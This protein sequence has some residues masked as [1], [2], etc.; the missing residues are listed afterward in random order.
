MENES[1]IKELEYK[2]V[3]YST[4]YYRGHSSFK[5]SD[6]LTYY[7]IEDVEF[8]S[9]ERELRSL[10]PGNVVFKKVGY[11]EANSEDKIK[12]KRPMLSIVKV[13][14]APE[15]E[16]LIKKG[17]TVVGLKL[18]GSACSLNFDYEQYLCTFKNAATRGSGEEGEDI[19]A[20]TNYVQGFPKTHTSSEA[21]DEVRG[22]IVIYKNDFEDLKKEMEAR[23]LEVPESQRNIV[24]GLLHRKEH[25]DLS[26]YLTFVAYDM[27]SNINYEYYSEKLETLRGH[28]FTT[29]P[30]DKIANNLRDINN[31]VEDYATS[32]DELDMLTDGL[33]FRID[34]IPTAEALGRTSHHWKHSVAYK[35]ETDSA[36]TE[37]TGFVTEVNRTGKISYVARIKP[38]KV[39]GATVKRCTLHNAS[40]IV[41]HNL[42]IGAK[43]RITRA[44]EVI[45]KFLSVIESAE[46]HNLSMEC[47]TCGSPLVWSKSKIDLFCSDVNC[48]GRKLKQLTHFA[49]VIKFD[50]MSEKTITKLYEDGYVED[51]KDFYN[52]T[53]HA[54]L[55]LE[56]EG[57]KS[58][59]NKYK[60]IQEKIE[61]TPEKF[62]SAISVEGLGK[63]VSKIIIE[64]F[65]T[66]P[67][68]IEYADNKDLLYER[69]K[70]ISGIGKIIAGNISDQIGY[71]KDIYESLLA[72]RVRIKN[73]EKKSFT[74]SIYTGVKFII[75]GATETGKDKLYEMIEELGGERVSTVLRSDILICNETST[76]KYKKA[77]EKNKVI[78]TESEFMK[79]ID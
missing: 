64:K 60:A 62:L 73:K 37:I 53:H 38:T 40:H 32:K 24:S 39:P 65:V 23:G 75:S 16:K 41:I 49:L 77:I 70:E 11:I 56:R 61:I 42:N 19:T 52:I 36:D 12:H 54:F 47:P 57:K 25:Q 15:V 72:Q 48:K 44:N 45:P 66:L 22:E 46:D 69:L 33:V 74:Q 68:F 43:I 4:I 76:G 6:G 3:V 31:L 50:G 51:F 29:N 2:L 21:I 78:L 67:N 35:V 28:G 5:A 13:H 26:I 55:N 20:T 18:D 10:D 79:S 27:F 59:V 34:H 8:D 58:A 30:V 9:M 17:G 71:I 1:R 7:P 14:S 63:S